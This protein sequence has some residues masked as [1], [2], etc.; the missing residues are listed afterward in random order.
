MNMSYTSNP[1]IGKVRAAAVK[2]V[3]S[4][5]STREVARHFGFSQSVIVKWCAKVPQEVRQFYAIPTESSRP[6]HHPNEL[7]DEVIEAILA[8]RRDTGRGA[9][10]IYRLLLK[11]GITVSL[12]S[13]KRTLSRYGLTKYSKWK[14]WHQ[15]T[16]RPLPELP[17]LLVETDTVHDGSCGSQ[18]YLYTLIDVNS[19][20]AYAE[21]AERITASR[22]SEFI[23]NAQKA[24]PF[25]F[26]TIQ[27]DHGSEFST[28]FT[29][30]LAEP[31]LGINHRYIRVRKPND[32][33]HIER[34][35]RT[36]QEE[37]TGR[38]FRDLRRWEEEVPKYIHHYNHERMHM[39][40]DWKT[41]MEVVR[42]YQNQ[43]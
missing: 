23:H 19:R 14:K 20:W 4:G 43:A 30:K 28:F 10:Y 15:S 38:V 1:N 42:E 40:L 36:I 3:R 9:D 41:P 6:R 7:Q 33:A 17:G 18:I 8:L 32:N 21:A 27:S 34:F 25:Q 12:S 5:R 31:S 37:C 13:V 39:S 35:N 24:A 29:K 22:S 11:Q 16:S 26:S 2:M